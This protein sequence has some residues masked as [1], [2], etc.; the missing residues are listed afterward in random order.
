MTTPNPPFP[1]SDLARFHE[2]VLGWF[3]DAARD[4]P[5]RRDASP[6]AVMVSEFMLQQTPVARVLPVYAAWL[7]RWPTPADLAAEATG[8][9]VRAWGRLGYPRRA[10]RLHAAAVAIVERHGG[11]V[12]HSREELLAL[13]GVGDYT[14]A[15]VESFA[16]GGRAVVLDTNVRR[17]F[18]RVVSG[19]QFPA[20]GVT[21]AERELATTL[22]PVADAH[23]WA[24]A[25]M[26]LGALVCTA[27]S[28]R[29][30][31]CPV[32]DICRWRAAG[33]PA[34]D[35]PARRG[36]AWDGTDRQCRGRL[37]AL[38]RD[39][40]GPVEKASLD[41]VW[42]DA[43]QRERCLDGLVADRLVE[44]VGDDSFALP[45]HRPR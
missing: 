31:E 28:P 34:Y 11:E 18:A 4:L 24:A 44:P 7:E 6:W 19:V 33:F 45:G 42:P 17:V 43:K 25:T 9:A 8:E 39:A 5:W 22:V 12:P 1:V 14:A 32:A 2:E 21:A 13:P 10:L 23:R 37:L 38:L 41:A 3:D 36:Q 29:C 20:A 27:R 30:E 16:F 15:A 40:P 26:E 35:G